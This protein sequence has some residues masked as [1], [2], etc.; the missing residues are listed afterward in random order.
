MSQ[1]SSFLFTPDK[2]FLKF[3]FK[4]L[5]QNVQGSYREDFPYI[6]P[7]GREMNYIRC[8]DVPIVFAS[9]VE[10]PEG[11]QSLPGLLT[12]SG[13]GEGM[14]V[15]FYPEKVC[16]LPE[17]GRIYHP[18][19]EKVGGVGLI[20]SS[21]AIEIS[22]HFEYRCGSQEKDPPSHFNWKG[23]TY[24]LDNSLWKIMKSNEV[25]ELKKMKADV[26]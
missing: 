12:Y 8:E 2:K 23:V 17:S 4:R 13:I 9:I 19:P 16:M 20:K 15:L 5:K 14:T 26:E 25:Q 21:L 1:P 3:F 11:G 22:P 10:D 6:S 24:T 7:C 18:A